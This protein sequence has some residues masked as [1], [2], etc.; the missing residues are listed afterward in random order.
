MKSF[1]IPRKR[2]I[3]G[4]VS[5]TMLLFFAA[6]AYSQDTT[7]SA[8]APAAPAPKPVKNTFDGVWIIDNQT[9]MVPIKGT[10][11]FDIQ[12]RFGVWK[13]GYD[14]FFGLLHLQTFVL[15][16]AIVQSIICLLD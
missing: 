5:I 13:N 10:F 2:I 15:Q 3:Q 9:V 14:D 12:H 16:R 4:L 8:A 1:I 7:D 11:E 6:P